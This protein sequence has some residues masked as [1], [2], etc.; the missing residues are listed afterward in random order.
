MR[1]ACNRL[2]VSLNPFPRAFVAEH[3]WR[4]LWYFPEPMMSCDT[5]QNLWC[6]FLLDR[7]E[8]LRQSIIYPLFP[9][10][11]KKKLGKIVLV[12]C[13]IDFRDKQIQALRFKLNYL[14]QTCLSLKSIMHLT[15]TIFHDS[16]SFIEKKRVKKW[17]WR[18][19]NK[20]SEPMVEH[21]DSDL[22]R[23]RESLHDRYIWDSLQMHC[24]MQLSCP[25]QLRKAA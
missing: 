12:S 20:T 18:K 8:L 9:Q 24:G 1:W 4:G 14:N 17:L 16:A 13:I 22:D 11:R 19:R 25:K 7:N 21:I 2:T 3:S 5:F 23:G 6:S 15:K 10:W